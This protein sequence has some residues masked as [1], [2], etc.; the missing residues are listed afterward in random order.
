[1]GMVFIDQYPLFEFGELPPFI[2]I[3]VMYGANVIQVPHDQ[4]KFQ[5]AKDYVKKNNALFI[6]SGFNHPEGC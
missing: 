6:E 1:M 2:K 4:E 3:G 5:L